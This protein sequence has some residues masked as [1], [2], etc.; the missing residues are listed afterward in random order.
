MRFEVIKS[1][2]LSKQLAVSDVTVENPHYT[3]TINFQVLLHLLSGRNETM[4]HS[5]R[6]LF[7]H[8]KQI[9]Q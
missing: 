5:H 3:H 7:L 1:V 9:N 6:I 4:N 8:S 2:T